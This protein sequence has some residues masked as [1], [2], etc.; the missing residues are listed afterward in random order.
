MDVRTVLQRTPFFAEVLEASE[1]DILA[2]L[3]QP[4]H[5]DRGDTL[6][7]E[8][9]VGHSMYVLVHGVLDVTVAGED[10]PIAVLKDGAIVGEM[11]LLTGARRSATVTA[12]SPVEVLEIGKPALRVVLARAPH[13]YNR[14]AH[15]IARR[16]R[17]LDRHFGHNAWGMFRLGRSELESSIRSFFG[18]SP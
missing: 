14:L 6:I 5:F 8:D 13:L 1:M 10:K 17:E 3:A 2:S 18:E 12:A 15:M 16:Q 11:S 4:E 9:D 7:R